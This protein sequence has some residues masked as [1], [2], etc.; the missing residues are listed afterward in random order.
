MMQH[1][2]KPVKILKTKLFVYIYIQMYNNLYNYL[3][4]YILYKYI[5]YI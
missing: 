1:E 4:K 2:T 3:H 5:L